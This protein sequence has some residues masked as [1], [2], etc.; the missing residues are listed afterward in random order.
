ML[1]S[2]APL[3]F[4]TKAVCLLLF[5]FFTTPKVNQLCPGSVLSFSCKW[6]SSKTTSLWLTTHVWISEN[7]TE[8]K[9]EV[10]IRSPSPYPMKLHPQT[11]G[12]SGQ[13]DHPHHINF[14]E[15]LPAAYMSHLRAF[16]GIAGLYPELSSSILLPGIAWKPKKNLQSLRLSKPVKLP[17]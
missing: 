5:C 16:R 2:E 14:P 4:I 9:E 8:V 1:Y 10:V 11:P 12:L 3:P 17:T 7:L 13:M 15:R 6:T